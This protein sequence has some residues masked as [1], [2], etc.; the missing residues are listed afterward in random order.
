MMRAPDSYMQAMKQPQS[1]QVSAL[2][3]QEQNKLKQL[4]AKRSELQHQL[5]MLE[6][7]I[8]K[9]QGGMEVL[10]TLRG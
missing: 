2:L 5:A 7:Q 3:Q 1:A 4:S 6:Q 10:Q 9:I 8:I